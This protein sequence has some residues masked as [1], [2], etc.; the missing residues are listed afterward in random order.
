MDAYAIDEFGQPGSVRDMPVPTPAEGQVR[1]TV[2]AAGMN[3]F[4]SAVIQGRVRDYME[5]RFP[6]VPGMDASGVV[7]AIG[8]G[9]TGLAEGDE[10][11]G[12]VGKMHVGD[13][14]LAQFATMSVGTIARKPASIDHATAA[15]IPVAGVTALMMLDAA[16]ASDGHVV[17]AVGATGGVGTYL[18]QLAARRGARV[19]AICSGANADYAR[20]LGA[21]DVIDYTQGEVE[22]HVAERHPDGIDVVADMHGDRD[23]VA[24][25]TRLV[26]P[27]GHVASAV[28]AAEADADALSRRGIGATNVQGR[29]STAALE[30]LAGMLHRGELAAPELH[31]YPL[32]DAVQA[33][34]A[35]GSGHT[36]GKI[37]VVMGG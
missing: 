32:G 28:G 29:V 23:L 20:G 27:G 17:V 10:A 22:A 8:E 19:V 7:E 21:A 18:V 3:P 34:E 11:F 37:V 6:L 30:T 2:V 12:S 26:R 25:L 1:I 4:D 9:V 31:S 5:H 14:T 24:G 15:S 16:S 36:R 13:G 33:L 35:V